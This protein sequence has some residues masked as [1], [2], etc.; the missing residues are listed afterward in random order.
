VTVTLKISESYSY[1]LRFEVSKVMK[2]WLWSCHIPQDHNL[3]CTI[4][5][6]VHMHTVTVC[7]MFSLVASCVLLSSVCDKVLA[8]Y[9]Q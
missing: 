2:A 9:E 4:C 3:D 6:H 5:M 7:D 1:D 8:Q